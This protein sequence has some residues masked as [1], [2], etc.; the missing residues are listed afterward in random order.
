MGDT[1][2]GIIIIVQTLLET[3]D[4]ISQDPSNILLQ[5]C[6]N[7]QEDEPLCIV[8]TW[9]AVVS[10]SDLSGRELIAALGGLKT[11]D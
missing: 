10:T 9:D 8:T 5:V 3:T 11:Y 1:I 7:A 2:A 4:D 6:L